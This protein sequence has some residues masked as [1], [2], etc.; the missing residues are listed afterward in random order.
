[1]FEF[2]TAI[3][4]DVQYEVVMPPG[5]SQSLESTLAYVLVLFF[6]D[7]DVFDSLVLV[8]CVVLVLFFSVGDVCCWFDSLVLVMCVVLVLFFSVGDVCCVGFIL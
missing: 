3:E 6:S 4:C 5:E 8:M 2:H 7:G 1:V